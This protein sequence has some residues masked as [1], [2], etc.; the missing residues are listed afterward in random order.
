MTF[1]KVTGEQSPIKAQT[2][3]VMLIYQRQGI[4]YL[5]VIEHWEFLRSEIG[6]FNNH[7]SKDLHANKTRVISYFLLP[8]LIGQPFSIR[9]YHR[10][11]SPGDARYTCYRYPIY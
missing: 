7:L 5:T 2:L 10:Y 1:D 11:I 8:S 3:F 9:L 6:T 4:E